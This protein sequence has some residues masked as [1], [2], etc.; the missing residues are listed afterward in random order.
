MAKSKTKA[1]DAIAQSAPETLRFHYL[2]SPAFRTVHADGFHG[3]LTPRGLIQMSVFSERF[4]IP[5]QVVHTIEEGGRLGAEVEAE[6]VGKIGVTREIEVNVVITP[7]TAT[8]LIEWLTERLQKVE[9]RTQK[10]PATTPDKAKTPPTVEAK[11]AKR[12]RRSKR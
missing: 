2:K 6:R 11:G 3:G 1:E 10:V 7:A 8:A 5:K 4:A 12:R 9:T